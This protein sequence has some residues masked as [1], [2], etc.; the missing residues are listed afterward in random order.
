[1]IRRMP[2]L[3][4]DHCVEFIHHRID[5]CD[6]PITIRHRELPART[7][8]LLYVDDDQGFHVVP[9]KYSVRALQRAHIVNDRRE[10]L[11]RNAINRGH[12]AK[13]PMMPANAI[14]HRI[15]K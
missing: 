6:H 5:R 15:G 4:Q 8:I 13:S 2:V 10:V 1:M 7:E 3:R 11:I 12:I 9:L 14:A